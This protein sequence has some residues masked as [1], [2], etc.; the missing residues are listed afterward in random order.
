M[1]WDNANIM[2]LER[3]RLA[4]SMVFAINHRQFVIICRRWKRKAIPPVQEEIA[5]TE[6]KKME[7]EGVFLGLHKKSGVSKRFEENSVSFEDQYGAV[8]AELTESRAC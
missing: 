4:M 1:Y 3:E 2:V 5:D 8:V 6:W 7:E